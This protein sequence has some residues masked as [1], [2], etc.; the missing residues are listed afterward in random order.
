[1]KT[2]KHL[3]SMVFAAAALCATPALAADYFSDTGSL[4][5]TE[6]RMM[7][8]KD[9][10]GA[11]REFLGTIIG[12]DLNRNLAELQL[13]TD[14]AISV[15]GEKLI[16]RGDHVIAP[17]ITRGDTMAMSREQNGTTVAM[18][19]GTIPSFVSY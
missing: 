2:R 15:A 8:G 13:P 1:M 10:F 6:L 5:R 9:V 19:L 3:L 17:T 18:D 14:V 12:V 7:A 11:N 16:D 4:Q